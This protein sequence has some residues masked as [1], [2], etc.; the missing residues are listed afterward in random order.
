MNVLLL[1]MPV[2]LS[3]CITLYMEYQCDI[4]YRII[5]SFPILLFPQSQ[6]IY[7]SKWAVNRC[8]RFMWLSICRRIMAKIVRL[9]RPIYI[10]DVREVSHC[11]KI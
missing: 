10:G 3:E 1:T 6:L 8:E 9:T 4:I 11:Q 2:K 5:I 7:V